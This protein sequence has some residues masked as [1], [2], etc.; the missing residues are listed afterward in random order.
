MAWT[1]LMVVASYGLTRMAT[2][3][4]I[5]TYLDSWVRWTVALSISTVPLTSTDDDGQLGTM[6][7]FGVLQRMESTPNPNPRLPKCCGCTRVFG[8]GKCEKW[9]LTMART[10]GMYT[11]DTNWLGAWLTSSG[12]WRFGH[13][14]KRG[15]KCGVESLWGTLYIF[16]LSVENYGH[17]DSGP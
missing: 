17:S 14:Y 13:H 6:L 3:L 10:I 4:V 2:T 5:L 8:H 15:A 11:W 9:S 16:S 12:W 1:P 7:L